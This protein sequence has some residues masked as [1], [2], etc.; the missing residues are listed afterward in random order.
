MNPVA[1]VLAVWL[2]GLALVCWRLWVIGG[3]REKEKRG[4]KGGDT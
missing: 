4:A 2:I 3:R 1:I